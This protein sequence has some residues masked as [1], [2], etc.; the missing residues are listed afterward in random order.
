M[1]NMDYVMNE[2]IAQFEAMDPQILAGG[3]VF[4]V[5]LFAA[6]VAM[7]VIRYLMTAIGYSKMYRKAGVA[8]WKAFIPFYN[9]Y[10]FLYSFRN[11]R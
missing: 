10:N 7:A 4:F 8:G 9:E 3:I 5:G 11:S 2:L 6:M 1:E